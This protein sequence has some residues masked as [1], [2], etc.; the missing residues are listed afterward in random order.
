MTVLGILLLFVCISDCKSAKIPNFLIILIFITGLICRC[1]SEAY[2]GLV[3][4]VKGC[5]LIFLITYP[6][7]KIGAVGAGDVKLFAV[8]SGYL[9]GREILCFMI[10]T[11]LFSAFLAVIKILRERNGR[12][13]LNYF[14]SYVT[15]VARQGKFS[16]Y[17][18][19]DSKKEHAGIYISIPV[20]L[21]I[22]LHMGGVY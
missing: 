13:R 3:T 20:F 8:T 22:L 4:Y 2:M 6:L 15:E 11:L 5:L 1:R 9:S 16:L 21:S 17:C 10:Y 19:D 12:E 18:Q 14:F 7:F